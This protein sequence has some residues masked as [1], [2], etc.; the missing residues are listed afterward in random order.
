MGLE[1]L[2]TGLETGLAALLK[3]DGEWP[4]H[5]PAGGYRWASGGGRLQQQVS[6]PDSGGHACLRT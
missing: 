5:C 4:L 2:D 6:F 1:I 3:G